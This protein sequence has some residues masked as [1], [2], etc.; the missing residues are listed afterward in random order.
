VLSEWSNSQ[1]QVIDNHLLGAME[2]RN[3]SEFREKCRELHELLAQKRDKS[4]A[5]LRE[6]R[7]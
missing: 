2:K 1:P 5:V 7:G 6:G 3:S 4:S